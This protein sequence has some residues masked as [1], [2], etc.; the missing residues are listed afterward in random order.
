MKHPTSPDE[1][2][3]IASE[4]ELLWNFPNCI[5][6]IDRKHIAIECPKNSGSLYYNYKGFFSLVLLAVCDAKYC[7]HLVDIGQYGSG[8][9]CSLLKNSGIER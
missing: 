8:N 1:W 2:M 4:F 9:D 3:L 7:F 5:G 6:A